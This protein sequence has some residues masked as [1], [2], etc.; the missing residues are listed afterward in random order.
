MSY[1]LL[2]LS[3][4]WSINKFLWSCMINFACFGDCYVGDWAFIL[5]K[6]WQLSQTCH[7]HMRCPCDNQCIVYQLYFSSKKNKDKW[8]LGR[9]SGKV[10]NWSFKTAPLSLSSH[11]MTF[12]GNQV[13]H[14]NN[15]ELKK[16]SLDPQD[17]QDAFNL[18]DD[19]GQINGSYIPSLP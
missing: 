11:R 8:Q 14:Q 10:T 12:L 4:S 6:S 19:N 17:V 9:L 18:I 1:L 15:V 7:Q 16:S 13:V 2:F 5:I 3:V